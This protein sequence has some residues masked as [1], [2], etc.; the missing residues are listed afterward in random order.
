MAVLL[1]KDILAKLSEP[2]VQVRDESLFDPDQSDNSGYIVPYNSPLDALF[3]G[4]LGKLSAF[5]MSGV[6]IHWETVTFSPRLIEL[7]IQN[8]TLGY[9]KAIILFLNALS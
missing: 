2:S 3:K 5:R 7:H 1:Q 6:N 8:V 9:D 4:L